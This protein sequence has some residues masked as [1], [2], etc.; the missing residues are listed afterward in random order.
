MNVFDRARPSRKER[1][2]ES[3]RLFNVKGEDAGTIRDLLCR[4]L[5]KGKRRKGIETVP[6]IA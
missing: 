4:P 1:S 6:R 2:K 3:I 5:I